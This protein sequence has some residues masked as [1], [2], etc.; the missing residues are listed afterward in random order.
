MVIRAGAASASFLWARG[1]HRQVNAL[2][3]PGDTEF[4]D[5]DFQVIGFFA[6]AIVKAFR[7]SDGDH[8]LRLCRVAIDGISGAEYGKHF[9]DF[10]VG[11]TRFVSAIIDCI[12]EYLVRYTVYT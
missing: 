9:K 10:R 7:D 4:I 1:E 3:Q 11:L 8:A 6:Q 5:A 12:V 2:N